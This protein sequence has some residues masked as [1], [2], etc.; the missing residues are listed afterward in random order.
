MQSLNDLLM[1]TNF[2]KPRNEVEIIKE[3]VQE[4]FESKVHVI[5][6]EKR[7]IIIAP[8]AALAATL[9]M[10][11]MQIIE[12]CNIQKQLVIRIGY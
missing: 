3:Y 10:I 12:A 5:S 4:Q 1:N 7:I 2:D 6:Q 11:Q 9:R 8:N